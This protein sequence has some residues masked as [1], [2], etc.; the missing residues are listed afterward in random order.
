[1]NNHDIE[2]PPLP[3][4]EYRLSPDSRAPT[5]YDEEAM[6]AYARAAIE[7][8]RKRRGE[9][10]AWLY[11]DELPDN[12]PYE[13]MVAYSKVDGVRMFPVY[14]PQP[15]EPVVN[16]SLT[17]EPSDVLADTQRAIIEA[18]ERRG[19]ERGLAEC[20]QD[21]ED[22]QRLDWLD[23]QNARFRVGWHV[24]RAPAGNVRINSVIVTGRSKLTSIREAI[25]AARA[26][27]EES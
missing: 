16:Q 3:Q 4:G 11:E 6:G 21:R 1:M 20:T 22:A 2:L 23:A 27:K 25:D 7:A 12:Y 17:T 14:T 10:V 19:Y 15:A 26:A 9:P 5:L 13:V 8:D 24:G 18:A